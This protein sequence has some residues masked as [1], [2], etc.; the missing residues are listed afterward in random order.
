MTASPLANSYVITAPTGSIVTS[1]SNP[2]NA[3]NVLATSDLTFS[4]TYPIGFTVNAT[5][6]VAEKSLVITSVNGVGN[7]LTNKVVTLATALANVGIATNSYVNPVTLVPSATKFGLCVNQTFTIPAVP[8]ATSYVWTLDNVDAVFV[9]ASNSTS[10]VVDF[11]NV[12]TLSGTVINLKVKATNGCTFSIE[13]TIKL[14]Y[15]GL[16]CGA[17]VDTSAV[18]V[19]TTVSI[20]PNPAVDNFTVELTSSEVSRMTMTI[21]N[22]NGSVVSSKDLELTEGNN[23]INE[24]ISSLAS[25]VYIVN[26]YNATNNENIVKRLVKN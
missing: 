5:T 9:G 2:S 10:V 21:Y 22:M 3:S 18:S 4:V 15:D 12:N 1:A 19:P 26:F 13:K 6:T 8:F 24:N 16:A 20:Y 17:K 25:G 23:V 7:S 11:S 14:T